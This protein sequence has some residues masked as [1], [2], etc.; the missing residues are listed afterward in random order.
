MNYVCIEE[1]QVVSVL[2]YKPNIPK[3]M[4]IVEIT[5]SDYTVLTSGEGGYDVKLNKVI[6]YKHT[7]V[8]NREV[9][10]KARAFLASTDWKILRHIREKQLKIPTSLTEQE[11]NKLEKERQKK[12]DLI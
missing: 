5:D 1:G 6:K 7:E 11:Y 3:S 10:N 9:S 8:K 2:N 4:T 12:A